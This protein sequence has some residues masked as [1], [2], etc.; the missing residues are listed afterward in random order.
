MN[1]LA[2]QALRG[3]RAGARAV[4]DRPV[5]ALSA[6]GFAAAA[7]VVVT[8]ARI[9]A[10]PSVLSLTSWLGL[11]APADYRVTGVALGAAM[12]AGIGVLLALWL[13]TLRLIGR[14]RCTPRQV[15]AMAGAWAAPFAVGPPVLGT[16]IYGYVAHGLLARR[17]L[18]PYHHGPATLGADRVVSA[19]D[20]TWRTAK[21]TDGPLALLGQ[22]LAVALSGG[23]ALTAVLLLRA[24]GVLTAVLLGRLAVELADPDGAGAGGAGG[25]AAG[26]GGGERVAAGPESAGRVAAGPES[27]GRVAAALGVTVLNPAVA[28]VVVS[29]ANLAGVVAALLLLGVAAG[30]RRRWAAAVLLCC[31]AAAVKPVAL[32]ALPAL[33][34]AHLS[35]L[36]R[37]TRWRAAA[38]DLSL[39]AAGLGLAALC[40]PYGLGWLA[41][42]PAAA[43]DHV[44]YAPSSLVGD[45]VGW[46]VPSAQ[47]DDLQIAGRIAAGAAAATAVGYLLLTPTRRPVEATI[48][49]ALL[50]AALLGPVVYPPF[51]LWG[52]LCLAPTARGAVR[53]GVVALSCA[54]CVLTPAG[55]GS[56]GALAATAGALAVIGAGLLG[57]GLARYRAAAAPPRPPLTAAGSRSGPR[58]PGRS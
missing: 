8:G 53:D 55:L 13:G 52:V 39:A 58:G 26:P 31:A 17:G 2:Q 27:A 12:L 25:V 10:G 37:G 33:V 41:N 54:A 48:G 5:P 16:D 49:Y 50:A 43:N 19:I 46:I 1:D 9:G 40:V 34:V 42:L 57:G 35:A 20:P 28:V 7:L 3:L 6:A 23:H 44:A 36:E 29:G 15:W 24:A 18:S 21:A 14:G 38:R 51:L 32:L 45:V 56:R 30:R 47:F 4:A 22:H 11:L